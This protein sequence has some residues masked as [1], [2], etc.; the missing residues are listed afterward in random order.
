[1]EDNTSDNEAIQALILRQFSSMTWG[2]GGGPD[3]HSFK[4]D[5]IAG[6]P[7]YP[8]ARP[9]SVKSVAKFGERM[10]E[11]AQTSLRS[12]HERVMGTR[13]HVFGNV[14]VAAVACENTENESNVSRNVE[15]MLLIKDGGRWKI[16]AQAWDPETEERQIPA[17]FLSD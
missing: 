2:T 16:A 6:A 12:F 15:M 14:A 3:L 11:L 9:L 8:S 10:S 5:F 7:L 17:D 1:M 13:V 4:D